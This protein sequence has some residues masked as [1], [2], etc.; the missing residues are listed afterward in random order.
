MA[1]VPSTFPVAVQNVYLRVKQRGA[2]NT[3]S[4][5][6]SSSGYFPSGITG[7][8]HC[9]AI[10]PAHQQ[11]AHCE[12]LQKTM[13]FALTNPCES[14]FANPCENLR[15]L[16]KPFYDKLWKLANLNTAILRNHSCKF[17]RKLAKAWESIFVKACET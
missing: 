12:S 6:I 13:I 17:A 8:A 2:L 16:A 7:G 10:C 5:F 3:C 15:K 14:P 4:F 9:S 11:S 1:Q